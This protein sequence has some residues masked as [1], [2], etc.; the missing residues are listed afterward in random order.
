M[1][2]ITRGLQIGSAS[3]M[4]SFTAK[5]RVTELGRHDADVVPTGGGFNID[6]DRAR[7]VLIPAA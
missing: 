6:R 2:P 4:P 1:I 7:E 3:E 5:L